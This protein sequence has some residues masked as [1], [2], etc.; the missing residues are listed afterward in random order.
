M[1]KFVMPIMIIGWIR[2]A[3]LLL[4]VLTVVYGVLTLV[5]R[6]KQKDRLKSQH[7]NDSVPAPL[8]DYIADG[9]QQYN[10]SLRAKLLLGVYLFP[11]IVFGVLVYFAHV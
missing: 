1:I 3:V 11:L 5:N 9:M 10:K 7:I 2:N 4:L 8:D 6:T